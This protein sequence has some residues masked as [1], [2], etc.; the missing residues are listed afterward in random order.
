MIDL[1]HLRGAKLG[2]DG[3][4]PSLHIGVG[5]KHILDNYDK[6]KPTNHAIRWTMFY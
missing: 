2:K 3:E 6:Y 1:I 5:Y 4:T